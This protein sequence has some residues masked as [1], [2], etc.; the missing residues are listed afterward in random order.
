[1]A[2]PLW[3]YDL[4]R[5]IK[6]LFGKLPSGL[7]E[8]QPGTAFNDQRA[9]A[10]QV[11]AGQKAKGRSWKSTTGICLHQ[12]A[13]VLGE[14]PG[15][16]DTVGCHVGITRAGQVMWL[17]N[18]D[19]IVA[20]GNGWNTQT[21][22]IEID[23]LY[24]GIEGFPATVWDDPSTK[25]HEVGQLP[26][27]ESVTATMQVIR[28]I[29]DT[30]AQNGGSVRALVAH[31]QA[32]A[33]RRNDPGSALWKA[34]ALPMHKELGLN[35]GGPGFTLGQGYPIPEAWDPRYRGVKY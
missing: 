26:T 17:H 27:P 7:P 5:N 18:F 20:H 25:V 22:G 3:Y 9:V 28:W 10:S 30:V 6:A 1:M 8:A 24:E 32:S 14:R 16:W 15:R 34:V 21:V 33:N 4:Q 23:G 19:K 2:S 12:T 13:C 11:H 29:C 31:R 35:D